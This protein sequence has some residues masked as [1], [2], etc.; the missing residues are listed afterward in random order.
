MKKILLLLTLLLLV[1]CTT[2]NEFVRFQLNDEE[3]LRIQ[4]LDD[5]T[6]KFMIDGAFHI[7]KNND[8]FV[9]FKYYNL[10]ACNSI[11]SNEKANIIKELSDGFVYKDEQYNY[12]YNSNRNVC[13]VFSAKTLEKINELLDNI[14]VKVE[15]EK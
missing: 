5:K 15:K 13:L 12:F 4:I 14:E 8:E 1:G 2:N 10:E 7:L 11:I 6:Y 9:E 3:K